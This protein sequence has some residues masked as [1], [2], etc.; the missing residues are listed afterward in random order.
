[1]VTPVL[2]SDPPISL[3]IYK[4]YI[5]MTLGEKRQGKS[6]EKLLSALDAKILAYALLAEA[7]RLSAIGTKKKSN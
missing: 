4:G 6:R 5:W 1:M 3:H 2:D 7:E